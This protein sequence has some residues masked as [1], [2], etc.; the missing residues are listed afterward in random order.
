MTDREF[1]GQSM[2]AP[3]ERVLVCRPESA[4]WAEEAGCGR[5]EEL[6]YERPPTFSTAEREHCVLRELLAQSGAEVVELEP[7]P[8]L[9]LDAVYTHD[10]SLVSDRGAILLNMGKTTRGC[11]PEAHGRCFAAL[12]IPTLGSIEPPSR[13]EGGDVVW[14]DSSTLLVGIGFRTDRAGAEEL[15]RI[16]SPYGVSVLEAPLPY[17]RGPHCCLHLMSLLSVLDESHLLVDLSW[18]AVS[19]VKMLRDRGWD[20]I[21]IVDDERADFACNALSLGEG[22]LVALAECPLTND[23]LCAAGFEVLTFS[24]V[25]LA[26][27]GGGGPTCLTRPLSRR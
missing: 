24:G 16:L 14:L 3:L 12:G 10:A 1:G 2:C 4:G 15:R 18:L 6:A 25:E 13:V 5:W 9:S 22:R 19:T 20:L 23:R 27:N 21:E 26:G 7:H 17:G 8:D 11:E